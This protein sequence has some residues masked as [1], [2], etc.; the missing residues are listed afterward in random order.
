MKNTICRNNSAALD[1]LESFIGV[2]S[3]F[4]SIETLPNL[5]SNFILGW[6]NPLLSEEK[7][8]HSRKVTAW[9]SV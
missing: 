3:D 2:A 6:Q 5:M 8:L 9:A 4:I 7:A 1:E